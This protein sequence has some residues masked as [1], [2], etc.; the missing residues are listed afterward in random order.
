MSPPPSLGIS[1]DEITMLTGTGL[2]GGPALDIERG[3]LPSKLKE[4]EKAMLN[5][6]QL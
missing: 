3:P 5:T 6:I 4:K 1:R 2:I